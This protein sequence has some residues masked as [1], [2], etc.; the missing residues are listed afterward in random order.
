MI[1]LSIRKKILLLA[2]LPILLMAA[3]STGVGIH[4][5]LELRSLGRDVLQ[6]A[7]FA[8][9]QQ[10][11]AGYME[12]AL[13][14]VQPLLE[15]GDDASLERARAL[16][17]RLRFDQGTGYFFAYDHQGIQVMSADNPDREGKAY[18][19]ARSPEGRFLVREY[20]DAGR[21]GG[22]FVEY[23]WARPGEEALSPK[24]AYV[25][26]VPGADWVLG[27]GFYVDDLDRQLALQDAESD[28]ALR[29]A[30]LTS[31]LS[32]LL[33]VMVIGALG[34]W[35]ARSILRP[36]QDAVGTMEDIAGGE[37]DLTRQLDPGVGHELGSLAGSFN[38]FSEQVRRLV[39]ETRESASAL[40]QA[41]EQLQ[42]FMRQTEEGISLQHQESD[43]VATAMN[44]MSASAQQVASGAERAAEEASSA[45]RR[46]E[47]AWGLLDGTQAVIEGLEGQV[48]EGVGIIQRLGSEAERI[49]GVLTV[50]HDVAEQTNLLALN[51]AIEAARAGDQGRGFAVVADEVR[52]LAGRT[53]SSTAEIREMI[54]RLQLGARE[55]V[56]SIDRI[57]EGSGRTVSEVARVRQAL[58]AVTERVSAINELNA[59]I[60][61]AAE[62]QSRVC[63]SIN[64]N[65][66]QIVSI[67]ERT[68]Q[69]SRSASSISSRLAT[70]AGSL[71]RLVG[72][73]KAD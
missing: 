15:A 31:G 20:L 70:I 52:T 35:L 57:R 69:G 56:Q 12:V 54:D 4:Q 60:A 17:R 21:S 59:Q 41:S 19:D 11:L 14:S 48:N 10:Q 7:L 2:L 40:N 45:E 66:H 34:L 64:A 6:Q 38:R 62:E 73:Y 68:A 67:S 25:A 36:L 32:T 9:R 63:E 13:S 39:R 55:A 33:L 44:Q 18:L 58:E 51:A 16:L 43:Q 61:S 23:N 1:T 28:N 47:A 30:L 46:V 71:H 22:G 27:T 49:G 8:S 26:P 3:V 37:G 72:R 5:N 42:D 29:Q 53:Q 24:L 50:I 65:V